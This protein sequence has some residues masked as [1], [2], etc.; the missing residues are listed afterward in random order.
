[1]SRLPRPHIPLKI[2]VHVAERQ[3]DAAKSFAHENG[4]RAASVFRSFVDREHWKGR[5]SLREQLDMFLRLLFGNQKAELHHRPALVNREKIKRGGIIVGYRPPANSPAHLFW[6]PEADH[7]VETR[8]RGQHGQHSDLGLARKNKRIA[9][10]RAKGQA[11][12]KAS[13]FPKRPSQVKQIT[14]RPLRSANRLP[15]KGQRPFRRKAK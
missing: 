15:G 12:R 13:G 7:D 14:S 10:N 11:R 4:E 8:V 6:L 2:R 1:M 3:F 5:S 9:K